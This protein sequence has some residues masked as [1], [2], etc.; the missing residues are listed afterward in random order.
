[1]EEKERG[2]GKQMRWNVK[3]K[4]VKANKEICLIKKDKT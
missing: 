3:E 1:M 4:N 2:R